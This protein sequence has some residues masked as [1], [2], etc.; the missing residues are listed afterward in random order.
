MPL[1]ITA[2]PIGN[3]KDLSERALE[4]LKNADLILAEDTRRAR[5][6][7]AAYK[8]SAKIERF[9][10]NVEEFKIEAVIKLLQDGQNIAL[11]SDAGT[12]GISDPGTKLVRAVYEK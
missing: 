9:D 3:L 10:Q 1:Y 5:A 6:L 7:L 2:T 4:T 12:P 8:I 11:V